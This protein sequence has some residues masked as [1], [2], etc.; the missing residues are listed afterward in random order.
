[1]FLFVVVG[2]CDGFLEV[3]IDLMVVVVGGIG[4]E[5]RVI[6]LGLMSCIW[7]RVVKILVLVYELNGF[8]LVWMVFIKSVG[9]W[10]IMVIF[11]C[12]LCKLIWLMFI[13][14]IKILFLLVFK[15]WKMV[16]VSEFLLVLVFLIMLIFLCVLILNVR[17]CRMGFSFLWYWVE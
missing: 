6:L 10:G 15:V 16:S 4:V 14:L 8:R 2:G 1:M 9:F 3:V 7:W 12:R 5:L 11:L 17:L 13:L